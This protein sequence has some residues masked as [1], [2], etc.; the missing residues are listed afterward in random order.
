MQSGWQE[1]LSV[2]PGIP[3]KFL[4]ILDIFTGNLHLGGKGRPRDSV[5]I[6]KFINF[7]YFM[8]QVNPNLTM[9]RLG[10]FLFSRTPVPRRLPE[11][12]PRRLMATENQPKKAIG[13]ITWRSLGII[14]VA[15][16]G[17][18]GFMYYLKQEKDMGE[19]G[20]D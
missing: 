10:R 6:G 13:P 12:L 19:N 14:S 4:L 1:V 16:A 9:S 3:W 20:M 18:M 5:F 8:C 17:V 11:V 15:G 2:F 7:F